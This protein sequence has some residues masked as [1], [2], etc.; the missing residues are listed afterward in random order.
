MSLLNRSIL[1]A[2]TSSQYLPASACW[3]IGMTGRIEDVHRCALRRVELSSRHLCVSDA[4]RLAA[5]LVAST[6][7]VAVEV[8]A[9]N[10]QGVERRDHDLAPA[11]AVDLLG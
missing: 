10:L 5:S 1:P 8:D 11:L 7:V 9:V 6:V 3:T 4:A 2:A